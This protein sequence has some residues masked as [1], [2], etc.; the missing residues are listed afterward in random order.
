MNRLAH[1]LYIE[2]KLNVL[3]QR[4]ETTGKLNILTLHNHSENFYQHFFNLLYSYSL[5]DL[6]NSLQNAEAIDIIDHKNLIIIQISSTCTKRKIESALSKDLIKT[7]SNY[8]FKFISLSKNAS[9]LRGQT[10]NNPHSIAF[11]PQSDIYDIVSILRDIK[12]FKIE[13]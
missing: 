1:F 11:N 5:D 6:N 3:A 7:H 9:N 4:I 8:T 12:A 10:F 13:K 2:E